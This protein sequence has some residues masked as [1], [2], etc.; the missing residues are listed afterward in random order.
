MAKN[1]LNA[2]KVENSK[3]NP[4]VINVAKKILTK[5]KK[6]FEVLGNGQDR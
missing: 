3:T 2:S 4:K 6:A 1:K 5:H